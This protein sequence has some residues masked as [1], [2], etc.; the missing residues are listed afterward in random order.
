MIGGRG[1]E[2]EEE[3]VVIVLVG[4]VGTVLGDMEMR[5]GRYYYC[6]AES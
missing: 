1:M 4:D 5:A 3:D 6:F 2:E